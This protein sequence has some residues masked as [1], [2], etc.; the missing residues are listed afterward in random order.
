MVGNE[1]GILLAVDDARRRERYVDW[2]DDRR[3]RTA[4]TAEDAIDQLASGVDVTLVD[5]DGSPGPGLDAAR[6]LATAEQTPYVI[7]VRDGSADVDVTAGPADDV[8]RRPVEADDLR[9]ALDRYHTRRDYE[10]ALE[11][12][13]GLTAKLAA[14]EARRSDEP[15]DG[16]ERYRRLQWLVEEQRVEV[17]EALRASAGDW[18]A[19]FASLAPGLSGRDRSRG[20]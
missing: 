16:N 3:V 5:L 7:L 12:L 20:T 1:R 4:A 9:G 15:L 11:E 8:L 6:T 14:I 17:D 13:Y 18:A 2:L 10:A 19:A